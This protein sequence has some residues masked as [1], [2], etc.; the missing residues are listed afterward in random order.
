MD[1][2]GIDL[3]G[4]EPVQLDTSSINK[5]FLI[6][7]LEGTIDR[8]VPQVPFHTSV[9]E[10]DVGSRPEG[11]QGEALTQRYEELYRELYERISHLVKI[12]RGEEAT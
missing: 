6:V 10:W 9:I 2:I 3:S 7:S 1:N 12:L 5:Y 11:L 4:T 8:Y